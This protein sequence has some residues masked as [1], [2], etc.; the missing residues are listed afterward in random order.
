MPI[1]ID[2]GKGNWIEFRDSKWTFGTRMAILGAPSDLEALDLV[3]GF[4]VGWNVTDIDGAA[5]P[6]DKGASALLN[7]DDEVVR[8]IIRAWF[9]AREERNRVPKVS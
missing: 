7:V 3:L 2:S 8:W 4:V 9:E 6:F 5:S 1:R